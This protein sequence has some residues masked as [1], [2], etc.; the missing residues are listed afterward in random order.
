MTRSTRVTRST[1]LGA[2]PG[3]DLVRRTAAETAATIAGREVSAVEV[4]QAD[5]VAPCMPATSPRAAPAT[6]ANWP[7]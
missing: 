3:T 6:C 4:T 2:G 5:S 7:G 1:G